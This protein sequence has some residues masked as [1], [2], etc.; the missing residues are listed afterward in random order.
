MQIAKIRDSNKI[1]RPIAHQKNQMHFWGKHKNFIGTMAS[2]IRGK[3]LEI[4]E[5]KMEIRKEVVYQEGWKSKVLVTHW[6]SI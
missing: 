3:K 6:I 5:G 1:N 4:E 2:K